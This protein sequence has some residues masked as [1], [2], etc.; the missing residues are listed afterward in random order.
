M[1]SPLMQ[2]YLVYLRANE[3]RSWPSGRPLGELP[4]DGFGE[5]PLAVHH[6][7]PK[8]FMVDRDFPIDRLN[9]VAN[10]SILWQNDNAELADS[11]P[12]DAWRSLQLNQLS[13]ASLQL[14]FEAN[15]GFLRPEAYEEFLNHRSKKMAEQLNAFI[16]LGKQA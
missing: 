7:F 1:Y 16:G 13:Y 11:D 15:D 14:C 2:V 5:D 12:M 6:I 3:A 9:S 10:Y 4:R 8:K